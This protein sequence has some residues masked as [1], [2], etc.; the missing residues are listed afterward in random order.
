[1]YLAQLS[2]SL[3][4][5][6]LLD[7]LKFVFCFRTIIIFL[8]LVFLIQGFISFEMVSHQYEAQNIKLATSPN[9]T[10]S[11]QSVFNVYRMLTFLIQP[12]QA[13]TLSAKFF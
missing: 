10:Q 13:L 7:E 12:D 4:R 3:M 5:F 8:A 9:I 2:K 6:K 1:M 11:V